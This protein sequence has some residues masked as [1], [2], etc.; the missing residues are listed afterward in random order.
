MKDSM[1]N[2]IMAKYGVAGKMPELL[3]KEDRKTV[4]PIQDGGIKKSKEEIAP[5]IYPT[6]QNRVTALLEM[7]MEKNIHGSIAEESEFTNNI[8]TECQEFINHGLTVGAFT[9][10]EVEAETS[11]KIAREQLKNKREGFAWYESA[12]TLLLEYRTE[13]FTAQKQL[14]DWVSM[15]KSILTES[16]STADLK[17]KGSKW[18]IDEV[19]KKNLIPENEKN[20]VAILQARKDHIIA[21]YT[22]KANSHRIGTSE[23]GDAAT[24]AALYMENLNDQIKQEDIERKKQFDLKVTAFRRLIREKEGFERNPTDNER[25]AI[26]NSIGQ[27]R[28]KGFSSISSLF[29]LGSKEFLTWAKTGEFKS[30]T[31]LPVRASAYFKSEQAITPETVAMLK[32]LVGQTL[33]F[34]NGQ[35]VGTQFGISTEDRFDMNAKEAFP[36]RSDIRKQGCSEGFEEAIYR[37]P[38]L[39]G[40]KVWVG[41][42][43]TGVVLFVSVYKNSFKLW[44]GN[45]QNV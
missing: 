4:L 18:I 21:Q 43:Q 14:M 9:A 45:F 12:A 34:D 15:A 28:Y 11:F 2:K 1:A 5:Y 10:A 3:T 39:R 33:M 32:G 16:G 41:G 30:F 37:Q 40:A 44:M 13:M 25:V 42:Q 29:P 23:L 22:A 6:K 38:F 31:R 35:M 26:M 24:Y 8:F 36:P 20:Y 27:Y 19:I 7:F 17:T